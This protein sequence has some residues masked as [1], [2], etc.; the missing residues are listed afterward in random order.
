[1]KRIALLLALLV[2]SALHAQTNLSCRLRWDD[3][4]TSPIIGQIILSHGMST[5]SVTDYSAAFDGS[6]NLHAFV[7]QPDTLYMVTVTT[8]NPES[9]KAVTLSVPFIVP[10]VILTPAVLRSVT[11]QATISRA[12]NA[13]VPGESQLSLSF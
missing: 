11:L 2:A 10:S 13:A 9:G 6:A 12:N 5:G 1:M 7:I 4:K 3:K 8:T